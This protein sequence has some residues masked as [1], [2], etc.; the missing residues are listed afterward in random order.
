MFSD[1]ARHSGSVSSRNRKDGRPYRVTELFS[2]IGAQRMSLIQ[3][4]IPHEVVGTSEIDTHAIRSYE[5][6]YGDNPNLGDITGLGSIPDSDILTYS[7]PC[8][9]L[10]LANPRKTGMAR[11]AN[12]RSSLLWEVQR[13]LDNAA[14]EGNLPEWLVMENV[15]AVFSK[16]NRADFDEWVS[17]LDSLGYTS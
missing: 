2:G 9:D 3:E 7:F 4:G 14:S 12:E 16:A 5:A 8:T 6:I 17:Y 10:S 15:P 1:R 13:L 11:G